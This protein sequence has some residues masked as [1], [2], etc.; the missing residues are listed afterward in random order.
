M[1]NHYELEKLSQLTKEQVERHARRSHWFGT[2]K[3][4][5]PIAKFFKAR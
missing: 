3:T 4:R 1:M 5:K 2:E